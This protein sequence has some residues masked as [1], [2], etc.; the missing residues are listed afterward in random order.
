MRNAILLSCVKACD[1][2]VVDLRPAPTS[3][4]A[5]D[6]WL[7]Q[8]ASPADGTATT[9]LC[10]IRKAPWS[11]EPAKRWAAFL[12]NHREAIAAMDFLTVPTLTFGVLY[13]FFV[14][15]HNRR[16]ILHCKATKNPT[17][18]WIVFHLCWRATLLS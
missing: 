14:I 6:R 12:N 15:E 4:R 3:E 1:R 9:V 16:R 2:T 18:T 8:S 10:W 13:C 11:P 7:R 17:C 5:D